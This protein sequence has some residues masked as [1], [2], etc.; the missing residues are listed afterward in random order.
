M[1]AKAQTQTGSQP[2]GDEDEDQ[3]AGDK[4]AEIH[5]AMGVLMFHEILIL[6]RIVSG[7]LLGAEGRL[8]DNRRHDIEK[9][10]L[11]AKIRYI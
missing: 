6:R 8:F 9:S 2:N 7:A 11:N 5:R 1:Q 4:N 3:D 10:E